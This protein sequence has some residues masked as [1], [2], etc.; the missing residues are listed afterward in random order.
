MR[1]RCAV[2]GGDGAC[3]ASGA[4]TG[5]GR[6]ACLFKLADGASRGTYSAAQHCAGKARCAAVCSTV[7]ALKTRRVASLACLTAI[8][9]FSSW[10]GRDTRAVISKRGSARCITREAEG[11]TC[12]TALFTGRVACLA[13]RHRIH[14]F[15]KGAIGR[16]LSH[17]GPIVE[18]WGGALRAAEALQT[19]GAGA[20]ST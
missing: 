13:T 12:T 5:A 17:A 14:N 19:R 9:V 20:G 6:R 15:D 7:C 3:C 11:A 10:T 18:E 1:A 16:A 4:A 2:A 8:V